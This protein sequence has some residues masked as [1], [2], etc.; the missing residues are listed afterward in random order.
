MRLVYGF[1][2]VMACSETVETSSQSGSLGVPI[3]EGERTDTV[4][5]GNSFVD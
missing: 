2:L 3:E 4:E 5:R 1:V